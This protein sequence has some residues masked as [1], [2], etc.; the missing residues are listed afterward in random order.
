MA[1]ACAS[2]YAAKGEKTLYLNFEK[3]GSADAFFSAEGQFD[4]SDII[5]ALKSR[6]ANLSMKMESCVKQDRRGVYFTR[7]QR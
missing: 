7:S 1:A 5:F 4:M 2:Y 3:F 6:K